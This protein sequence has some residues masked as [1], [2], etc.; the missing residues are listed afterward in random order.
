MEME[1]TC[2]AFPRCPA[3]SMTAVVISS[4]C[5][6]SAH[7]GRLMGIQHTMLPVFGDCVTIS[8]SRAVT[9]V[10]IFQVSVC[11]VCRIERLFDLIVYFAIYLYR[12]AVEKIWRFDTD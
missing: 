5:A 8:T 6:T 12:E 9:V 1:L 10:I 4:V 3:E 7:G 2:M 11:V